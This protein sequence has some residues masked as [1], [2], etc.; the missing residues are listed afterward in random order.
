MKDKGEIVNLGISWTS[1]NPG[2][3]PM[4]NLDDWGLADSDTSLAKMQ[5]KLQQ[6][7]SIQD[8]ILQTCYTCT[9][10]SWIWHL[11]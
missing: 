11:S 9:K 1:E 6:I 8:H 5:H 10:S 4:T 3:M 7:F 2:Y